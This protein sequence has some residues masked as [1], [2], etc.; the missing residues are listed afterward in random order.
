MELFLILHIETARRFVGQD[1]LGM[2]DESTGYSYALLLTTRELGRLMGSTVVKPQEIK[3][4]H[5]AA[6][7]I[8]HRVT[9]NES[10]HHHILHSRK[11]GQKL[12]ELKDKADMFVSESRELLLIIKRHINT[13][14]QYASAISMVE[15]T[16]DLQ[17]GGLTCPTGTYDADDLALVDGEINTLEYL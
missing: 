14:E 12:M 10:R 1:H 2:V 16:D 3:H 5:C 6:S 8:S 17:Q 15:R 9:L 7:G 11:L 13:I 4:L